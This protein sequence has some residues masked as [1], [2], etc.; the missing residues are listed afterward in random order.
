MNAIRETTCDTRATSAAS[1]AALHVCRKDFR[2]YRFP[3][4]VVQTLFAVDGRV[5]VLAQNISAVPG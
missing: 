4:L 2:V 5:I 1:S 3:S